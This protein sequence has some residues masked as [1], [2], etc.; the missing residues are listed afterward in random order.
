[1]Q[2]RARSHRIRFAAAFVAVILMAA[3]MASGTARAQPSPYGVSETLLVDHGLALIETDAL[4][5]YH[6]EGVEAEARRL[7]QVMSAAVSWYRARLDWDQPLAVAVLGREDWEAMAR[8]PYPVPF[9]EMFWD[10][11][12]MPDSIVGFPGFARWGFDPRALNEALTF[13]EIGHVMA[14][15]LGIRSGNHFVEELIANIFLAA[16]VRAERPDLAFILAGVP[17]GFDRNDAYRSLIDLD[18][19]YAGVGLMNYAWFQFRLAVLADFMV[20]NAPLEEIIVGLREA[21]PA[22]A[23]HRRETIPASLARLE[24]V[25]PGVSSLVADIIGDGMLPR[26]VP[27]VCA[28]PVEISGDAN[29]LFVENRGTEAFLYRIPALLRDAIEIQLRIDGMLS[30]IGE[31]ELQARAE[32]A[33]AE[34]MDGIDSFEALPPGQIT[35]HELAPGTLVETRTACV[36]MPDLDVRLVAE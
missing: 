34:A 30:E 8:I 15:R 22:E 36:T 32:T 31:D 17:A 11:V 13:H 26:V 18:D 2:H 20:A 29:T 28:E 10:V 19:L 1:M 6:S 12:V 35:R 16:Y 24:V 33:F 9:A 27:G 3:A 21:F 23:W 25:V 14:N 4:R 7:A 5:L